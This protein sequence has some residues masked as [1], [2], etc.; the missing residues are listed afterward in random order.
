MNKNDISNAQKLAIVG[1]LY[2][3]T[4]FKNS[5][6]DRLFDMCNGCGSDGSWFR[7]PSK[8]YG[9]SIIEACIIHDHAYHIGVTHEDKEE[10]DRAFL[11]NINRLIDRRNKW[12]KPT[13]LQRWRA[14]RYYQAVKYFGGPAFWKNK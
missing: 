1:A 10:A 8:I 9:T 12:Y 2:A 4:N 11:N 14:K 6:I 3:L 13:K 7:P 5:P